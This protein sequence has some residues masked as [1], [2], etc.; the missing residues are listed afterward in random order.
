M[1]IRD[2]NH[3][4]GRSPSVVLRVIAVSKQLHVV[5]RGRERVHTA[6]EDFGVAILAVPVIGDTK[7]PSVIEILDQSSQGFRMRQ[8]RAGCVARERVDRE[9]D[10]WP[11]QHVDVE[12][13]TQN[14]QVVEVL[15]G[16]LRLADLG[17]AFAVSRTLGSRLRS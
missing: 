13:A 16:E 15:L 17:E 6:L 3:A 1:C 7:M 9:R 12:D 8:S 10:V 5:V 2:S 4:R 11:R 14:R